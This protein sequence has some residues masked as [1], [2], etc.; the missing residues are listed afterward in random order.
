[1]RPQRRERQPAIE[2]RRAR[3]AEGSS[4]QARA[5]AL[6]ATSLVDPDECEYDFEALSQKDTAQ[7]WVS[8]ATRLVRL[9]FKRRCRAHLGQHL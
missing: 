7:V 5:Q 1:M 6:E 2:P 4:A 8:L 9:A 3:P